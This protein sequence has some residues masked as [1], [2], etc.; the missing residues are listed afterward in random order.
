MIE[1]TY[2]LD[3][4]RPVPGAN[5]KWMVYDPDRQ[6]KRKK[7]N[8]RTQSEAAV[9]RKATELAKRRDLGTVQ[10][11]EAMDYLRRPLT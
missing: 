3:N 2:T 8:L 7:I 9:M 10:S 6:P 1:R 4:E 5:W 11:Q